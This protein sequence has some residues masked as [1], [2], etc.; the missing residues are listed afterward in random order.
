MAKR[1][2]E[3]VQWKSVPHKYRHCLAS[4]R[5][6]LD[7]VS[8]GSLRSI[9]LSWYRCELCTTERLTARAPDGITEHLYHRPDDYKM[10]EG[11]TQEDCR[12]WLY[13]EAQVANQDVP[14]FDINRAEETF[15]RIGM[16]S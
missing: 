3:P 4:H 13:Y 10:P 1:I 5:H 9:E 7:L 8:G 14:K 15:G 11:F 16:L 2:K 12:E 6:E